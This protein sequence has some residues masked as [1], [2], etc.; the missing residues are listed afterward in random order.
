MD[1]NNKSQNQE[2]DESLRNVEET[3]EK[4]GNRLDLVVQKVEITRH[5]DKGLLLQIKRNELNEPVK[6]DYHGSIHYPVTKKIYKGSYIACRPTKKSKFIE[7]ELA[8][9]RKLGQSPYI[10][11]FYGLSNVDNHE[12]MIFDW[13][14]MEL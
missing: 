1:I 10:L 13:L 6:Q 4:L 3:F 8:I 7:E 14:K 9:L 2:V 12:V 11:Q 5:S